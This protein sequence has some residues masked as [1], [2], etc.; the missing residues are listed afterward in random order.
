[1]PFPSISWID[2]ISSSNYLKCHLKIKLVLTNVKIVLDENNQNELKE[3]TSLSSSR[4]NPI[5]S[6]LLRPSAFQNSSSSEASSSSTAIRPSV[7]KTDDSSTVVSTSSSFN[8]FLNNSTDEEV[9]SKDKTSTNGNAADSHSNTDPLF[10]LV[11][12]GMPKSNLFNTK[13]TIQNGKPKCFNQTS[14]CLRFRLFLYS[15]KFGFRFRAKCSWTCNWGKCFHL[16][17]HCW[18]S[19]LWLLILWNILSA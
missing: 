14:R 15:W 13:S 17:E 1:M 11:K 7:L 12:N 4:P 19:N 5:K 2:G 9:Q 6:G 18:S 3:Q 8:P 10:S 16:H